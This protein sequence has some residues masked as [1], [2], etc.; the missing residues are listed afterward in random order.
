MNPLDPKTIVRFSSRLRRRSFVWA[1][2]QLGLIPL[3]VSSRLLDNPFLVHTGHGLIH[4]PRCD[5]ISVFYFGSPQ[6]NEDED[7]LYAVDTQGMVDQQEELGAFLLD[8]VSVRC[9][10]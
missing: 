2:S 8:E 5:T 1:V 3:P 6:Y 7:E 10:S 9:L 4:P